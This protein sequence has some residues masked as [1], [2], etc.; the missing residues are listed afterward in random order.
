MMEEPGL[1]VV[2]LIVTVSDEKCS[3]CSLILT[4]QLCNS[5]TGS[6]SFES[7]ILERKKKERKK[8]G[9]RGRK[10]SVCVNT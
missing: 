9:G 2:I 6:W 3:S 5:F 1:V 4:S 8:L 7:V 10:R